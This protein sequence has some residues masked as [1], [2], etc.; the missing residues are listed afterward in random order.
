MQQNLAMAQWRLKGPVA[1]LKNKQKESTEN[2]KMT[3][4]RVPLARGS[5]CVPVTTQ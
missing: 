4:P 1:D 5:A 3:L 2:K